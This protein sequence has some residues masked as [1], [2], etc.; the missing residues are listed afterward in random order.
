[1]G[2]PGLEML[3]YLLPLMALAAVPGKAA[4]PESSASAAVSSVA[5]RTHN[6]DAMLRF[7]SEAFGVEFEAVETPGFTM[8]QGTLGTTMLKLVPIRDEADFE[9]FPVHQLGITVP[10]VER[11]IGTSEKHG[12]R[13]LERN[14]SAGRDLPRAAIRDP[15]GNS[16]ELYEAR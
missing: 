13:L 15:D 12:G 2:K 16:I 3:T 1:M 7:Y 9:G 4:E 10:D 6:V 14:A 11:V 5:I 8:H